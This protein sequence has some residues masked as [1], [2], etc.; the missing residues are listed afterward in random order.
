MTLLHYIRNCR[1][2]FSEQKQHS[3]YLGCQQCRQRNQQS[4]RAF[5]TYIMFRKTWGLK[6]KVVYWIYTAVVRPMVTNVATVWWTRV[7]F[8]TSNAELSKLQRKAWE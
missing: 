6:L 7:K 3:D 5:W 2:H 8:K 1:G 4:Y